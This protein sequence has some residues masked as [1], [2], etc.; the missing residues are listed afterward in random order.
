MTSAY[1]SSARRSM[2]AAHCVSALSRLIY[3]ACGERNS[4]MRNACRVSIVE[5]ASGL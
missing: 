4:L 3:D 2:V 1:S 5:L